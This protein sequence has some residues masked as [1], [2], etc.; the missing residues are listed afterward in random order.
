[1]N[2]TIAHQKLL[3]EI[4]LAIGSC[5]DIRVWKRVVG[6]DEKRKIHYGIKGESDIDGIKMGGQRICIE[7]KTGNAVQTKEQK[8]FQA[9]IEKFGG[10]YIL[11]RSVEDALNGIR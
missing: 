11:A 3:D 2:N 8:V 6:F 4:L 5:P 10:L 9:M 1:M 7:V